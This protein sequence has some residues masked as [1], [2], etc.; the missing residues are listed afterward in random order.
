MIT[1]ILF[2]LD[3][4]LLPMDQDVFAGAYFKGLARAAAPHGY[5][6]EKLIDTIWQGTA[7]MIKNNG[8]QTNEEVF[9][10]HFARVYGEDALKDTVIF[11][12]FYEQNF[13]KV[14]AVCGFHPRTPALIAELKAE[15]VRLV[16]ATNPIFPRVATNRR[17]HWAGLSPEDFAYYTT[18]E[19][20]HHCKPNLDYYRDILAELNLDPRECIMVGNDVAEDMIAEALGMQVFLL[21]DCMINKKNVDITRYP[22]GDHEALRAYLWSHIQA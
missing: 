5:D 4:T 8:E 6:P 1:T 17:I 11:D 12:R 10:A 18:Y 22:H 7:A 15:G 13:D 21:T 2:D 9:W 14:Q 20:A 16:L 19:N 3:G